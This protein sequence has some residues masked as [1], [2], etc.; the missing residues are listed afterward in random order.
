MKV[1]LLKDVP[2]L[3]KAE[4]VVSVNDGYAKNYLF[5]QGLAMEATPAALNT[6][7]TKS[8][9]EQARIRRELDTAKKLGADIDGKTFTLRMKCGEGGRLYGA[10]TAMD[11]AGMLEKAG[12]K[13][14]KRA[15]T[16]AEP[17]RHTGEFEA[18]IRLHADVHVR[19]KVK[20]EA[21][22]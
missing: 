16:I 20:V 7:R 22:A 11:V 17:V 14:D 6:V 15:I 3:G 9:A 2:T 18:D 21:D 8:Q 13:I 10:V 12:R 4:T 19:I 1:I 5:R